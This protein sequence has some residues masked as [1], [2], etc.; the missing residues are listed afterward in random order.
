MKT[1]KQFLCAVCLTPLLGF[2]GLAQREKSTRLPT[3]EAKNVTNQC[4]RPSPDNFTD[5]W[6][7][8]EAEIRE[9]ESRFPQI[10]KLRV[11]ECCIRGEQIE[12]PERYY[13]QYIGIIVDGKNLIYINA[14]PDSNPDEFWKKNAVNI[15][16]GGT[17][18]GVLYDP[19]TKK[20][21]DLAVNGVA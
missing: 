10:K 8:S 20:F 14:F 3:S 1:A 2:S 17:A 21:F 15:C 19:K 12:N 6:Q 4:S 11:K 9:M 18:W 16:D 7:P 5:T 13:M